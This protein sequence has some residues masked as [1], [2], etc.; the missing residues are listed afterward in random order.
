[1]VVVDGVA[2]L[3]EK[4]GLQRKRLGAVLARLL[5]LNA[6]R[7]EQERLAGV[8]AAMSGTPKPKK[9]TRKPKS[10]G[11]SPTQTELLPPEQRDLF[12]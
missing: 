8:T 9:P 1:M 5:K 11:V 10:S 2:G 3:D 6:E 4:V 7:A 12:T